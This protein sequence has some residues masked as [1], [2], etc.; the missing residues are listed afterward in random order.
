MKTFI[1]WLVASLI[2]VSSSQAALLG[3]WDFEGDAEDSSSNNYHGSPSGPSF[4]AG[5]PG[6][7][8]PAGGID[9][10]GTNDYVAIQGLNF[11]GANSLSEISI[12]GWFKTTVSVGG[13]WAIF[14]NWSLLD[15]DRSEYFNVFVH[16][17]GSVG[18]SPAASGSVGQDLFSSSTNNNN[19]NWH[20]VV[21]V[22]DGTDKF[23]YVDGSLDGTALNAHGGRALGTGTT[24]F[25]FIGDGSEAPTEDGT[26]NNYF[27]DGQ[28]DDIALFD[29]A[30]TPTEVAALF[31]GTSPLP[32]LSVD[33][34]PAPIL[35]VPF[36]SKWLLLTLIA[37]LG[38]WLL[39]RRR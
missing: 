1:G 3:F 16:G 28:Y 18:F 34:L 22:Y 27:Y 20:H 19:G 26:R 31:A 23:I 6:S 4:V 2:T 37:A 14:A 17:N 29:H 25:G 24:R 10:D 5:A 33:R 21:A 8:T 9:F 39:L 38:G 7:S 12:A 11:N 35:Y 13:G 30:L 32:V 15:F 36:R